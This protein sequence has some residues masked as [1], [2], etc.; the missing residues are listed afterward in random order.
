M[1]GQSSPEDALAST[2]SDFNDITDRF[3]RDLQL[4]SYKRSFG[5]E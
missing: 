5:F 4:E 3:G 1:I 2:V